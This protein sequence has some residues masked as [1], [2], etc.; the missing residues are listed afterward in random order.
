MFE[1]HKPKYMTKT[2]AIKLSEEHQQFIIDFI[3]RNGNQLND[4]LQIFE[5]YIENNQQWLVQRQ[6]KPNRESTIFVELN[7]SESINRK[8]WVMDQGNQVIVLFPEDY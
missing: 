3:D 7:Y 1:K 6:E 2:I 4:Y 8:V 5:F